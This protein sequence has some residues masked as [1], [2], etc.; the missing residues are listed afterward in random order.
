[1][2]PIKRDFIT[3]D[4]YDIFVQ[5]FDHFQSLVDDKKRLQMEIGRI[6]EECL[7]RMRPLEEEL[8]LVLKKLENN[9]SH[10]DSAAPEQS[11]SSRYQRGQL[12]AMIKELLRAHPDQTFKPRDIAEQLQAKG[13]AISLW[14][15]K[16]G[17]HDSEIERI[18]SGKDG[19]R[20]IY[21]YRS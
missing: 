5:K 3:P 8:A 19:K 21:R 18:P 10:L 20:F 2:I 7:E 11:G 4:K 17:V 9:L 15:N 12:G 6:Q 1:M 14:F 16:Y 13:T